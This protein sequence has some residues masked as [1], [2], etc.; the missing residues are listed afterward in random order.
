MGWPHITQAACPRLFCS[1]QAVLTI[2]LLSTSYRSQ[3]S[4]LP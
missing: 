1:F 3:S 4:R 2:P